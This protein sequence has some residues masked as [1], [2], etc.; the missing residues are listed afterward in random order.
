MPYPYAEDYTNQE[1]RTFFEI[2]SS[3]DLTCRI[4]LEYY[5]TELAVSF[6][7]KND[8]QTERFAKK[9]AT[10]TLISL[11]TQLVVALS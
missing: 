8:S 11:H 3:G 10:G 9:V 5:F 7:K 2:Y 6:F 1:Y 4:L